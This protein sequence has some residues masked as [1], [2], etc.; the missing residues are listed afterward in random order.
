MYGLNYALFSGDMNLTR[1]ARGHTIRII[2][3]EKNGITYF[4]K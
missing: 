3:I 4:G 1:Q 2:K